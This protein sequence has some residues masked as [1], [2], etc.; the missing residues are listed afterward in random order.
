MSEI[1]FLVNESPEGGY[2]ARALDYSIFTD[3]DSIEAIKNNIRDAISCHFDLTELPK[4]VR[5]HFVHDE[6]FSLA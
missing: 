3:G 5:L 2:S 1:I 4:I 6:V